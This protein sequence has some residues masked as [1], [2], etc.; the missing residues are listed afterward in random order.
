MRRNH[1]KHD[2]RDRLVQYAIEIFDLVDMD[3][4][5]D[6]GEPV[7][8]RFVQSNMSHVK[9]YDGIKRSVSYMVGSP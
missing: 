7:R 4:D 3:S 5:A 2:S 6:V 1:R 9:H 8:R